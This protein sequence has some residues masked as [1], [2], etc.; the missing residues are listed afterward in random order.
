MLRAIA[1]A[2]SRVFWSE[3]QTSVLQKQLVASDKVKSM[4]SGKKCTVKIVFII[5]RSISESA[6]SG[7]SEELWPNYWKFVFQSKI[8]DSAARGTMHRSVK[9]NYHDEQCGEVQ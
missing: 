8:R 7:N 1:A 9:D 3:R 5:G 6:A 2:T 4:C